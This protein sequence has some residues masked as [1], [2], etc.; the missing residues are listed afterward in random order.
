MPA[1]HAGF[2][3]MVQSGL[4][5]GLSACRHTD[6]RHAGDQILLIPWIQT[7]SHFLITYIRP[8][9]R[10]PTF[11]HGGSDKPPVTLL[12]GNSGGRRRRTLTTAAGRR[13]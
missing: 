8:P 2:I 5:R 9:T 3:R 6:K 12:N 7:R 1:A 13:R 11:P 10:T 4:V